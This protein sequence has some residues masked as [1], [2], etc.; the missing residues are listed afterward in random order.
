MANF[1][2]KKDSEVGV[3]GMGA[4]A[5]VWRLGMESRKRRIVV[6]VLIDT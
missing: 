6:G 2:I 4:W 1:T 5:R 3:S